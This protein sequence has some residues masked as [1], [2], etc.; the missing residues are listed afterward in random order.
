MS[1]LKTKKIV[2]LFAVL[3]LVAA[4]SVTA[5]IVKYGA[6]AAENN[7]PNSKN[8]TLVS[9]MLTL[10]TD[11]KRCV[12]VTGTIEDCSKLTNENKT[13]YLNRSTYAVGY[14]LKSDKSLRCDSQENWACNKTLYMST[15]NSHRIYATTSGIAVMSCLTDNGN[16]VTL[17]DC[18]DGENKQTFSFTDFEDSSTTANASAYSSASGFIILRSDPTQCL[19]VYGYVSKCSDLKDKDKNFD[20]N[21][22]T[23]IV[24]APK[25][26]GHS[27]VCSKEFQQYKPTGNSVNACDKILYASSTNDTYTLVNGRK[28]CAYGYS[29][30]NSF[31]DK[32]ELAAFKK[33]GRHIEA[34]GCSVNSPDTFRFVPYYHDPKDNQKELIDNNGVWTPGII[35]FMP[36]NNR[37]LSIYGYVNNCSDLKDNGT[38]YVNRSTG[39][40]GY[41]FSNPSNGVIVNNTRSFACGGNDKQDIFCSAALKLSEHDDIYM[42]VDANKIQCLS[43][44]IASKT[45]TSDFKA[46]IVDCNKYDQS[47]QF[48]FIPNSAR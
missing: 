40:I 47:Q 13:F 38:F 34:S 33:D 37:C 18:K 1:K 45:D 11:Q 25:N 28:L 36:S 29:N 23:S 27:L 16:N 14:D 31:F 48:R 39:V 35:K 44:P 26:E 9:G 17:N 15:D 10:G 6:S 30:K 41:V 5:I 43:S 22:N 42:V 46:H 4:V 20:L 12:A 32:K 19:S 24:A 8:N 2:P 3:F 21:T 7:D